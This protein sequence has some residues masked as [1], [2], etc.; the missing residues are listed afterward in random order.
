MAFANAHP[1]HRS[2][3]R[4]RFVLTCAVVVGVALGF[5][6]YFGMDPAARYLTQ[7]VGGH[8]HL[9]PYT[10]AVRFRMASMATGVGALSMLSVGV[11]EALR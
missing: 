8:A 10:S 4:W 9:H 11:N 2:H 5:L 3:V 7:S 1:K 6:V